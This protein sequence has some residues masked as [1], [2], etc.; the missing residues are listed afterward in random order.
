M[1]LSSTSSFHNTGTLRKTVGT[2]VSTIAIPVDNDGILRATTGTFAITGGDAQNSTGTFNGAGGTLR[3][4]GQ[5]HV[6]TPGSI[7]GKIAVRGTLELG[8]GTSFACSTVT[9][10]GGTLT[11]NDTSQ[12]ATATTI[13]STAGRLDGAGDLTVSGSMSIVGGGYSWM[14]GSG[15]TRIAAGAIITIDP[16]DGGGLI[17]N[18]S[19][20][21][22]IEPNATADW[23]S[24]F[25]EVDGPD[26]L[27]DNAGTFNAQSEHALGMWLSSTSSFHNTGTLR[28]TVGTG[29][30]TIAIPV[31]ND[32]IVRVTS[33]TLTL[34]NL[35]NYAIGSKTLTGGTYEIV[36]ATLRLG[37]DDLAK[38][39]ATVTLEGSTADIRRV[40]GAPSISGLQQNLAQGTITIL[41]GKNLV[42]TGAVAN[43]GTV[44][45]GSNGAITTAGAYTQSGGETRLLSSTASLVAGGTGVTIV[46]GVLQGVGTVQAATITNGGTVVPGLSPGVLTLQGDYVQTEGGRLNIEIRGLTPGTK[47]DVLQVSGAATLNGTLSITTAAFTPSI[48]NAFPILTAASRSGTFST[49][50]GTD[51]GGSGSYRVDYEPADVTLRVVARTISIGEVATREGN[52]GT[53][54]FVFP[55]TLSSASTSE[56]AAHF[57]TIDGSASAGTDYV[58]TSGTVTIPANQTSSSV[59]V[60]V[61]GDLEIEPNETFSVELS[62]PVNVELS[63]G[64]GVGTIK[65]DDSPHQLTITD[66]SVQE[67][68]AGTNDAVLT[69]A[70]DPVNPTDD[71]TVDFST[72]DGTAN[73]PSDLVATS[74]T[75]TIPAGEGS[76]VAAVPIRGDVADEPNEMFSVNLKNPANAAILDDQ[77]T[78]TIVDD[79]PPPIVSVGDVAV[80]EGD[81]GTTNATFIVTLSPA[82]GKQVQVTYATSNGTAVAPGDYAAAS[83]S[84]TFLK[85]Q[86]SK[87]VTI[88]VKGDT[89]LEGDESFTFALSSPVNATTIAGT[90]TGVIRNDDPVNISAGTASTNEGETGTVPLRIPV[91]LSAPSTK[92]VTVAFLSQDGTAT[93]TGLPFRP[94]DY[95]PASGT[96]TFPPGSQTEYVTI[97]VNGDL[98]REPVET[99][100]VQL[101]NPSNGVIM[102]ALGTG[103]ILAGGDICDYQG[104]PGNDVIIGG[105]TAEVLCGLA[106][107]DRLEGR[108]GNDRLIG[109]DGNDRLEGQNGNDMFNGG[110]GIDTLSFVTAS[111]VEGAKIDMSKM[112]VPQ[113]TSSVG[114]DTLED[115]FENVFGSGGT[116]VFLGNSKANVISGGPDVDV[117]YGATGAD[118]ILGEGGADQLDGEAGTDSMQGGGASDKCWTGLPLGQNDAFSSCEQ[119]NGPGGTQATRPNRPLL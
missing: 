21:L 56:V 30:S 83:G 101:S 112:G 113:L 92:T 97:Q 34:Q 29:V 90:A 102:N 47:Y 6:G 93:A 114:A 80:V 74:G 16:S 50:L 36:D 17:L 81:T 91:H 111:G 20:T 118:T 86:T 4:G 98:L 110:A 85:G 18:Q 23:L 88:A 109:G 105:A 87:T 52:A 73:S 107:D 42:T 72:V 22:R 11:T 15:T 62:A 78:V 31:D 70:V 14:G 28:K 49:V 103:T 63:D 67:G 38:N 5:T 59:T 117:I 58:A 106:G 71:I 96:L 7:A 1:W 32:G 69:V 12:D 37:N 68:N 89:A 41:G 45:L 76:G 40:S 13:V 39:A 48:G 46:N 82:S 25:I 24:G 3:F 55:V 65:N 26:N 61:N 79:D 9:I 84:L 10:E 116:D 60:E 2:G 33:G 119:V 64:H 19:R 51:A 100:S 27:I 95:L 108:N 99:L 94:A 44:V 8:Q 66:L 43:A 77:A 75:V 53:T 57:E 115:A 35:T 54:D 104:T